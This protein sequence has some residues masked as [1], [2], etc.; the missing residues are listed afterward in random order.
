[1]KTRIYLND[2]FFNAGIVGFLRILEHNNNNFVEINENYIEFDTVNLKNFHKYYFNYFFDKYNLGKKTSERIEESFGKINKLITT[3]TEEKDETRRIQEQIKA[4]KKYIKPVI[5]TQMDKIKKFDEQ[6]YNNILEKYN[7]IDNMKDVENIKQIQESISSELLKDSVNKRITLNLFKSI[8]GSNYFGQMSFLN[9]TKSALSYEEQEDLMYKDYI[10]NIIEI[11]FLTEIE[12]GEYEVAKIKG[13]IQEKQETQLL[14]KNIIAIYQ[15]IIKQIEKGKNLEEIQKYIKEKVYS[16]CCLCENDKSI[17]SNYSE[18]NFVPLAVSSDN[19]RNFFW[20]QNVDFPICD[21]CKLLLFCT[22]AGITTVTKTIKE[23]TMNGISYKE[24]EVYSFV[25]YDTDVKT[26]LRTNN[27]FAMD[28]RKDKNMSNPYSELILNIVDQD[29]KISEWQL[30]NIFVIEFET[31]YG[32]YSRMEYFNIKR[33]VAR[34]FKNYAEETFN[35]ITDY[36]FKIEI[37][38]YIL[39]NKDISKII[40]ERLQEEIR[41]DRKFGFNCY[42]ATKVKTYLEILKKE[43]QDMNEQIK[44]ANAK[45]HVMFTLGNEIYDELKKQNNENKLDSYIYK[46]L[47]CI[48][49]NRKDEFVDT[50]IRVIWSVGKDVP[51]I[52]VKNCEEVDWKEL[53]HSF[54]SGLTQSKYIKNQEVKEN[55]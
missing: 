43:G 30:Q 11:D 16:S 5:K 10:S 35:Q 17:T 38:D 6:T 18:G 55:E 52:L 3:N 36:K 50:A 20:N 40:N 33:Y 45:L 53:G 28:S 34:F 26:L 9:I 51:E 22:P 25:N 21:V 37:V 44:S 2:W 4:E 15:N 24:K 49:G 47:N 13:L 48:K 27:S 46:M 12:E 19:M 14:S 1:M 29:K 32:A 54:I 31:E 42:L 7:K 41:K 8:L 39:K 23:N